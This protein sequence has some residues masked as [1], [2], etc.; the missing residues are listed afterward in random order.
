MSS[1]NFRKQQ[2]LAALAATFMF[3]AS[4]AAQTTMFKY[5]GLLNDGGSPANGSLLMQFKLFDSLGGIGKIGPTIPDVPV[6]ASQG[7]FSVNLDFGM[8]ALSGANR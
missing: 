4:V 1:D 8:N 5:Q 7:I 3:A 6:T 2:F